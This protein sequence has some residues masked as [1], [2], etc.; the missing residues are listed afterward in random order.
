MDIKQ[1]PRW[2]LILVIVV[3]VLFLGTLASSLADLA[4][5]SESGAQASSATPSTEEAV[6]L[7]SEAQH[8]MEEYS[9]WS[10]AA[11]TMP[12]IESACDYVPG[13]EQNLDRVNEIVDEVG[14][15]LDVSS[16]RDDLISMNDSFES[17]AAY[18]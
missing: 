16:L 4:S 9:T 6:A 11:A 10:R 14:E 1:T 5:K 18:C 2:A 15:T 3:G 8:L 13:M 12:S 7:L 17:V